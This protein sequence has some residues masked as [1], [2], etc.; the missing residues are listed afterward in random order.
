MD[1]ASR[2]LLDFLPFI[3]RIINSLSRRYP[4]NLDRGELL[5]VAMMAMHES[6]K[7]FDV[8]A[9]ASIYTYAGHRV[10]GAILDH[11]RSDDYLEREQRRVLKDWNHTIDQLTQEYGR[12]PFEIEVSRRMGK[13]LSEVR[14][15]MVSAINPNHSRSI[16]EDDDE[17]NESGTPALIDMVI[18]DEPTPDEALE[19]K[20]RARAIDHEIKRLG[21][22]A[23]FI[24]EL[25]YSDKMSMR[26]IGVVAGVTESAVSM[27]IKQSLTKVRDALQAKGSV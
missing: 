24:L 5:S 3:K 14:A 27:S 9:G 21:D 8:N 1:K 20:Q 10:R 11:L 22:R 12:P 17:V 15:I 4:A 7:R 19:I 16:Y 25:Y 13:S 26:E 23:K 6:L 2:E 18:S